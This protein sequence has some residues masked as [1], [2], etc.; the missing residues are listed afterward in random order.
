MEYTVA[1]WQPYLQ[2]EQMLMTEHWLKADSL[3]LKTLTSDCI[4]TAASDYEAADMATLAIDIWNK[5]T[6]IIL[7]QSTSKRS[8]YSEK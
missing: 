1:Q 8:A 2:Q 7:N 6:K 5:C 3:T 4:E